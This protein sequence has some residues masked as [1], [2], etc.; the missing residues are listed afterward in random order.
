MSYSALVQPQAQSWDQTASTPLRGVQAAYW[1]AKFFV[2]PIACMQDANRRFGC[3]TS[4]GRLSRLFGPERQHVLALGP[5]CNRQV[6]GNTT[7]FHTT[8][9]S[10]AG[11]RHSALRRI[12]N[13][14]TRMNGEKY[15]QQRQ[16][17]LPTFSKKAVEG[18]VALMG[19]V[20]G[21]VLDKQWH[22]GE[23]VDIYRHM[24]HAAMRVSSQILFGRLSSGEAGTLAKL[25]QDFIPRTFSP[26]VW[27]FPFDLP[28]TP[29]RRMSRNAE[30][31]ER[32]LLTLIEKRRRAPSHYTDVL[33]TLVTAF[34]EQ[35]VPMEYSDL[36][37][38]ATIMFVASYENVASVLTWTALLL[39]QHPRVMEQLRAELTTVLGGATPSAEQLE[40]LPYLDAVVK[41]SMRVLP[42]VPFL[43]RKV[44]EPTNLGGFELRKNDRVAVSPYM[45]HHA[46]ELYPEPRRFVPE[47]WFRIKPD[48]YEYLPF[49][50]GPRACIGKM[51]AM[52]EIKV[53]LA[54]ILQR[55][56]LSVPA[57]TR[58]DRRVQIMMSPKRG[59]PMTLHSLD[60][61]SEVARLRGNIH[62]MVDLPN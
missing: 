23:T 40:Q 58:V 34:D 52:R 4:A 15:R 50:A 42:P 55:Y 24:R 12:R 32:F 10:F 46:P 41:E 17:L 6:L 27:M 62:E 31:I 37:G 30:G 25:T 53:A 35:S 18:Y 61:R 44:M 2:D 56:R 48:P 13:G 29:Y 20:M 36:I 43:V 5:D 28:L 60:R 8:A 9:Q 47:R 21:E 7:V 16:L 51:F 49:G 45:T 57:Q 38:Q 14:L 59:M 3:V 11:S 33:N 1:Y 19:S 39:A 54:M 26:G 22:A